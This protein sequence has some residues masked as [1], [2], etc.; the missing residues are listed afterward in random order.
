MRFFF[1]LFVFSFLNFQIISQVKFDAN[2]ESGNLAQVEKIDS[3]DFKVT[4]VEDIG[5]RWFYFRITGVK[6]KII[7]VTITNSDVNRALFSYDNKSYQRFSQTEAPYVNYF[8]KKFTHDTVF[9]AYYVPYTFSYLQ[10]R[11]QQWSKSPYVKLDTIGYTPKGLPQQMLII[12]DFLIPDSSKYRVWIHARTH[13]GETPGSF[14]FDGIVQELLK[15][16]EVIDYY[17]KKIIFYLVPFD[18]PDG[19]FYGRSRTNFYGV[20]LER[21][22]DKSDSNTS[23]EVLHLK[24]KMQQLSKSK[25][26]SI[27]LNLHSQ[28]SSN[29]TFWIHSAQSTSARFYRLENQFA[30]LNTSD[31]PYF[32]PADYSHSNLHSYFPE[33]WLWNNYGEKVLALTYETPYD[34][35]STGYWVTNKNLFEI[36][37]RTIY[38]I[39]EFLE[40]S[41][42]KRIILDNSKAKI[43][44][45]WIAD[46][47]GTKFFGKDYYI[48]PAGNGQTKIEY[49]T[50]VV[51]KGMYDVYAWWQD[52]ESFA[53]DAK[54]KIEFDGQTYIVQKTERT[55]GGQ[56][57][58]IGEA[59]LLN[60]GI[61][62]ITINNNA[63]DTVEADA[64][65]IIY[66]GDV[67]SVAEITPPKDF[68]L[69]QNFPNPFNPSTTIRFRLN[70][71]G[72]VKLEIFNILGE[73]ITLLVNTYLK[74]GTYQYIFN[75]MEYRLSSGVYYYRLSVNEKSITKPMVYLK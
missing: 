67:S 74:R 38:S 26:F 37:A 27:F 22:W 40:L 29:C 16:D 36:G 44:G 19:V 10:K 54:F 31:N 75:P 5:G 20:D 55:N 59:K 61:I 53:F 7:S 69:F 24:Q 33:G 30:N 18:N 66:R 9:V 11:I 6:N 23:P 4:T 12:T 45:N 57:N 48:S 28:A 50:G 3:T 51:S 14:H 68:V 21:E 8:K 58:F 43:T 62:T 52:S 56:W 25:P 41:T 42:P 46:T 39:G 35:Y 65:R 49:S 64:F 32:T 63:S 47:S 2:F 17:R 13:P 34:H 60:D 71:P 70:K 72:N 73:Q 1:F 15:N